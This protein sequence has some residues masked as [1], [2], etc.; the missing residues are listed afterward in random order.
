M[1][2]AG[3]PAHWPQALNLDWGEQVP[4]FAHAL[5]DKR[6]RQRWD[7]QHIG[8]RIQR[9]VIHGLQLGEDLVRGIAATQ[10]II[11]ACAGFEIGAGGI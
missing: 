5:C 4:G 3:W 10:Q 9:H 7:R 8:L 6:G 1:A 2:A 11:D